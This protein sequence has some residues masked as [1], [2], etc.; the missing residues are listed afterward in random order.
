MSCGIAFGG[1]EKPRENRGSAGRLL[2]FLACMECGLARCE[3]WAWGLGENVRVRWL[4]G[5]DLWNPVHR[6][7][8]HGDG[9]GR[10]LQVICSIAG[11]E[12]VW[13]WSR[14]VMKAFS[15]FI[16]FPGL[17]QLVCSK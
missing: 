7:G 4:E 1:T 16:Y 12:T 15:W 17:A 2:R 14:G 5:E 3:H 13:I 8:E 10:L 6:S 9:Q 11:N